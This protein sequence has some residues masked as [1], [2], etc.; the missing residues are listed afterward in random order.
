MVQTLTIVPGVDCRQELLLAFHQVGKLG[1][2]PPTVGRRELFPAWALQGP[3]GRFDCFVD[4]L[5][6]GGLDLHN[7]ELGAVEI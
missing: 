3:F 1:H 2:Q 4:I 5:G 7:L 6:R